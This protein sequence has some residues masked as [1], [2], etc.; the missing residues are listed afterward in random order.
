MPQAINDPKAIS[1]KGTEIYNAKYRTEYEQKYPGKYLAVN[2]FDEAVTLGD[3]A[4]SALLEAKQSN[5]NGLF[6]LIWIGHPGAFEV[7][8]AYRNISANRVH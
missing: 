3:T 2:I 7:G 8:L 1:E 5:P 4:S 6:H